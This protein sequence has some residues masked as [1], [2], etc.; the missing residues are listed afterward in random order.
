MENNKSRWTSRNPK[1]FKKGDIICDAADQS[2]LRIVL[3]VSDKA[4]WV[5]GFVH[6]ALTE[7]GNLHPIFPMY[8][9]ELDNAYGPLLRLGNLKDYQGFVDNEDIQKEIRGYINETEE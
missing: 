2:F 6:C 3:A 8:F 9:D 4:L 7:N 5:S 1:E